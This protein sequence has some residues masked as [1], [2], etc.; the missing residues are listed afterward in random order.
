MCYLFSFKMILNE[1]KLTSKI[2]L[3]LFNKIVSKIIPDDINQI[4]YIH[5]LISEEK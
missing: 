2:S 1:V 3:E 5:K 4:P